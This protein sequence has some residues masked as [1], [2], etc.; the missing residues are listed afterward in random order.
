MR[1]IIVP[2]LEQ[3]ASYNTSSTY[4]EPDRYIGPRFFSL[5]DCFQLDFNRD[6]AQL[7]HASINYL[8]YVCFLFHS[9]L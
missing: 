2:R 5:F 7:S 6:I 9:Y 4:L 3:S 8:G 1:K